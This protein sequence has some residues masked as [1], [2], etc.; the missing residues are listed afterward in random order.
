MF[1]IG[2]RGLVVCLGLTIVGAGCTSNSST[3]GEESLAPAI[4]ALTPTP[5][6]EEPQ[7]TRVPEGRIENK[8]DLEVS[9][10]FNEY[11]IISTELNTVTATT[12][13]VD[14]R[15]PHD[16]EVFATYFHPARADAP[17][18]GDEG[19]RTWANV[20]CLSGFKDYVGQDFVVS[21]LDIGTI[22]PTEQTWTGEGLHREVVCYVFAREAQLS[23]PMQDSGI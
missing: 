2:R 15:R 13:V 8:Y 23:G 5:E 16:G 1:S 4:V 12:T 20:S 10:C 14:C 22:T 9:W 17:Y 18:P 7:P 21:E 19:M 6:G 3:A 11:E